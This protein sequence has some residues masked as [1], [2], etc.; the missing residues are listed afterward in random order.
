[1]FGKVMMIQAILL[2]AVS[3][4]LAGVLKEDETSPNSR[5][6]AK[7]GIL[8]AAVVEPRENAELPKGMLHNINTW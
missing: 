4:I 5:N 7:S 2:V 8:E 3:A 6:M 1:M